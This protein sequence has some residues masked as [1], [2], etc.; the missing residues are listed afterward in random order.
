MKVGI[1]NSPAAL[2]GFPWRTSQPAKL[3]MF[4]RFI[5]SGFH[6]AFCPTFTTGLAGSKANFM[7]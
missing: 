6:A 1:R 4:L 3:S 5:L 7:S 2:G